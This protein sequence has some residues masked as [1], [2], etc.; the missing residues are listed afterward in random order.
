MSDQL[1]RGGRLAEAVRLLD[2]ALARLPDSVP[3]VVARAALDER[4]GDLPRARA[5]L[6]A[7]QARRP[8]DR[9]LVYQR[10]AL[11]ERAGDADR[12]VAIMR[13][14][15]LADDP[16]DVMAL[17]FIGYSYANRGVRLDEAERLL[18]RA[19]E[20]SPDDGYLLD[21]WGWLLAQR[22]R[23]DEAKV[24]LERADRLAP[25]EPEI[26]FHLGEVHRRRGDAERARALWTHALGLDPDDRLRARIEERVQGLT[27]APAGAPSR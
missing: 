1:V 14:E 9:D 18:A 21:S 2:D 20:L 27:A 10:A 22:D 17:N 15:I 23:L 24:V 5:R 13:D 3:L 12:A 8:G 4:Q 26:L 19:L 11:E 7:A 6:E 25:E 16:D